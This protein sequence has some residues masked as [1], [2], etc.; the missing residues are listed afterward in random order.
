MA[1][2][3][4]FPDSLKLM[5]FELLSTNSLLVCLAALIAFK[6]CVQTKH[7]MILPLTDAIL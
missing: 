4:M 7:N 3:S 5:G 1:G 2:A 6:V